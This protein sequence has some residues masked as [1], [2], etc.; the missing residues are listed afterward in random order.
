M[1]DSER[2]DDA[3]KTVRSITS[4]YHASAEEARLHA[5]RVKKLEIEYE[6]MLASADAKKKR[7]TTSSGSTTLGALHTGG[8]GSVFP[9][10]LESLKQL[11]AERKKENIRLEKE[12]YRAMRTEEEERQA[13]SK[14]I[15]EMVSTNTKASL[16]RHAKAAAKGAD[17][18]REHKKDL[19]E[20]RKQ[21]AESEHE[22]RNAIHD[23]I[24]E[25]KS[26]LPKRTASAGGGGASLNSTSNNNSPRFLTPAAKEV[27]KGRKKELSAMEAAIEGNIEET[28][29]RVIEEAKL[30]RK[31]L[32][33]KQKQEEAASKKDG[34]DDGDAE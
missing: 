34:A 1:S 11:A 4:S 13:R 20:K 32:L 6:R 33:M 16:D 2:V 19:Y 28:A 30:L 25:W 7:K 5:I 18:Y 14:Y 26:N 3:P 24:V 23:A 15:K 21:D 22:Y 12:R 27:V 8:G 17:R 31:I 29:L 9:E 10:S